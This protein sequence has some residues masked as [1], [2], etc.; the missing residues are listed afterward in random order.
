ML[1]CWIQPGVKNNQDTSDWAR[2]RKNKFLWK[3]PP[4][5]AI[6]KLSGIQFMN[7]IHFINAI[8]LMNLFV[9]ESRPVST[10]D[11]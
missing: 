4:A 3:N 9:G 5:S 8:Q 6:H 7:G 10:Y 2:H 11:S 1:D